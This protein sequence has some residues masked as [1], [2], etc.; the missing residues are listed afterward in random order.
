M[1][2]VAPGSPSGG[3][4]ADDR[5]RPIQHRQRWGRDRSHQASRPGTP[6]VSAGSTMRA[7]R[8]SQRWSSSTC[9]AGPRPGG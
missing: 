9:R 7:R 2:P 6:P 3:D 4:P 8:T 1:V 5:W